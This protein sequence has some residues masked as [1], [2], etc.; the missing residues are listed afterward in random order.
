MDTDET[1]AEM[2]V[3]HV[4]EGEKHIANQTALI[5]RLHLLGL[6]T[7]DAQHLLQYFCQ[8]QAQHEEHLHR[9][10]DECELGLRDNRAISSQQRFY[11]AR[12]VIQ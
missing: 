8:L 9:T 3:R 2:V 1:P 5:V 11:E 4:L 10:S 7:E 6:P 12:K